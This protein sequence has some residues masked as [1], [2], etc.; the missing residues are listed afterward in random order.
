M[1]FSGKD[2]DLDTVLGSKLG[3]GGEILGKL[4][5]PMPPCVAQVGGHHVSVEPFK[6]PQHLG[7]VGGQQQKLLGSLGPAG[8]VRP[9]RQ[10]QA[11]QDPG[12]VGLGEGEV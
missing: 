4:H 8:Y 1:E 9:L 7:Q 12:A 10:E 3:R 5:V 2:V 11:Q 6:Q